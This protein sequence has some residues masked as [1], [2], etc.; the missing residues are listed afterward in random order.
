MFG[1]NWC[2]VVRSYCLSHMVYT[3]VSG[4]A[5]VY[6]VCCSVYILYS[7]LYIV[8]GVVYVPDA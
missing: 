8:G 2:M 6:G 4:T 1:A 7:D 5:S 3:A